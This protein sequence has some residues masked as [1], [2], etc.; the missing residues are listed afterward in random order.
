M[1][2]ILFKTH[3]HDLEQTLQVHLGTNSSDG[4]SRFSFRW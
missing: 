2:G 4:G 3:L 1:Q